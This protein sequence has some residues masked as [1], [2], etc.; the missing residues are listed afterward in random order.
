MKDLGERLKELRKSKGLTQIEMAN[1]VRLDKSTIAKYEREMCVPS[2]EVAVMLAKFF[3]VSLDY[4][5]GLED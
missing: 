5:V 2:L 1:M 4:L 3:N